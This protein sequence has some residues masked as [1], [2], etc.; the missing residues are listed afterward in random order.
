M[1][2]LIVSMD[3]NIATEGMGKPVQHLF[4]SNP[5]FIGILTLIAFYCLL[6]SRFDLTIVSGLF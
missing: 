6:D 4:N 1:R 5:I 2:Y 3:T